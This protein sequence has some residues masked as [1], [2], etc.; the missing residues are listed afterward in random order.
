MLVGFVLFVKKNNLRR[1]EKGNLITTK[2]PT[3][4]IGNQGVAKRKYTQTTQT[5][6]N[7]VLQL[8]RKTMTKQK[9]DVEKL[10]E[11]LDQPMER[12]NLA[13]LARAVGV[14]RQRMHQLLVK[15]SYYKKRGTKLSKNADRIVQMLNE[16][17]TQKEIAK[18]IGCGQAAVSIFVKKR[19]KVT[20]KLK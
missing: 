8:R 7:Y 14:S 9:V 4:P 6:R 18:E 19:V 20:Y 3:T 15:R 13:E 2:Q 1:K 5:N 12:L 11:L 17:K 10:C 16:G